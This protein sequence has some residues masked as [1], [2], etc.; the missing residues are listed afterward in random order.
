M[1]INK[2]KPTKT[3]KTTTTARKTNASSHPYAAMV[4]NAPINIML[5]DKDLNI[6]YVNPASVKT[7][8]TIESI[9]PCRVDE[10]LG[11]SVD[12]FHKEPSYQRSILTDPKAN[13]PRN[14]IIQVGPE[15]LDLLVS[16]I[17]GDKGEY[18]G[19][20]VTW[21]VVTQKLETEKKAAMVQSMV[22]GAPINM[23]CC[24]LDFKITYINPASYNTLKAIQHLLPIKADEVTGSSIDIFHK[25][26]EMQRKLLSDENNLPFATKIHLGEEILSLNVAAMHDDGGKYS[27]AMVSWEVITQ[28]V[29]MEKDIKEAQEREKRQA[30]ELKQKVDSLLDVVRAASDGDLTRQVAV[31]GEDAVGQ[32]GE[33]LA[34]MLGDLKELVSQIIEASNQIGE[35]ANAV[36]QGSSS[37]AEGAQTTGATVE[38]MSASI[39][40]LTASIQAISKNSQEADTIATETAR[41]AEEGGRAVERSVEAMHLINKSSEQISDIIKVIGEIAS[42]TN[43]LALNAAIEAARAGEHGLGFAVVA[44]EVRKLAERSSE[45]AKEI[46]ALIKE[47]TQRVQQGSELSEQT[48]EALKKI[49]SGVERTAS[50]I[51]QIA[52]ATEEQSATADEVNKGVQNVSEVTEE[53]SAS[54]EEMAS[55]SEELA[56]QADNLRQMISKFKV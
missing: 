21:N 51:A 10:I 45:A 16:G 56:A 24:D 6:T 3:T 23:M 43:L 44:D 1:G 22:E 53:N 9:L 18:V 48:G 41:E 13:L 29:K 47:S 37:L 25:K 26:P 11:K 5:A 52:S 15:K 14:A 39:E 20:M 27:G 31:S 32:L 4:E 33:G 55:S 49:I 2:N 46:S 38:E 36:S 54:S 35:G 19:A 28:Q 34:G 17:Y 42:Q 40:Q 50:S 8:K 12:F 30:E 7:L